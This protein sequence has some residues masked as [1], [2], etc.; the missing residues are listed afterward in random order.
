MK[1]HL[2]YPII[3]IYSLLI[4]KPIK[5]DIA[6]TGEITLHGDV[7]EI[8]GLQNKIYG[9]IK[10]GISHVLFPEDN[11]KDINKLIKNNPN[12]ENKIKLTSIK[13]INDVLKYVF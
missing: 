13:H 10:S 11:I 6:I 3:I 12:I 9:A 1:R 8:G 7:T 4:N 2:L 5:N